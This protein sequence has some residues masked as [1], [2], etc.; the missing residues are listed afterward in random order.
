M[1]GHPIK[2]AGLYRDFDAGCWMLDYRFDPT[3]PSVYELFGTWAL[4]TVW[5][6]SAP[7]CTVIGHLLQHHP[8]ITVI[9]LSDNTDPTINPTSRESAAYVRA[10]LERGCVVYADEG[11]RF[12]R[13]VS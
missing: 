8:G 2:I 13:R 12:D 1:F 9:V 7:I 6:D 5:A 10:L 3:G 4:P 11:A